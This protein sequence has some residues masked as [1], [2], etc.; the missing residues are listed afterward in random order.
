[1]MGKTKKLFRSKSDRI[2]SGVCAGIGDYVDVDPTIVRLLWVVFT[3]SSW[4]VGILLYILA[5]II[6]PEK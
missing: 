5:A 1:M 2:L 4:G 3:F 6:I